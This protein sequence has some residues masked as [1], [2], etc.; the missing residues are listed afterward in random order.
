[1]QRKKTYD[2]PKVTFYGNVEQ[3][4]FGPKAGF[5]DAFLGTS[6]NVTGGNF[7][8]ECEQFPARCGS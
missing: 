1:M 2:S 6:G 7:D 8:G 4:T 5:T 3:I